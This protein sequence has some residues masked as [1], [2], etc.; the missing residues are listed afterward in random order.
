MKPW[1]LARI[2]KGIV[3]IAALTFLFGMIV[4]GL[5]NAL[6]PELFGGPAL[7]FWQAVGLLVLTHILLRGWMPWR[8]AHAWRHDRWRKRMDEK[9]A[10]MTPEEREK[11]KQQ[12]RYRCGWT[13][14]EPEAK[15]TGHA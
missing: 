4:M 2:A 9:L 6:I 10:A 11:F 1:W 15:S 8:H 14:D 5:W 12:W 13:P 3:F 7:T